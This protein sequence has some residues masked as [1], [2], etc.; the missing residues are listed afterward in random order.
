MATFGGGGTNCAIPLAEA[1][2]H[3]RGR[4]F[5]GCV[6]LSDSESWV[7]TGRCGATDVLTEWEKF[8]GHL[9]ALHAGR[10]DPKLVCIDLQ[11]YVTGQA[12]DR[13]DVLNVG[14]FSDAVFDVVAG[15]LRN[16]GHGFVAEV[17]AIFQADWDRTTPRLADPPLV[18]GAPERLA[19]D[20]PRPAPSSASASASTS[21]DS[22][23]GE[24]IGGMTPL[25]A[26]SQVQ[27][28]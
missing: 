24:I 13:E 19:H 21:P 11:P 10:L 6:L 26:S 23:N 16:D 4:P 17:E 22:V 5:A 25:S 3:L 9:L 18:V 14:G 27:F 7:G 15:F 1:N 2:A 12:P 28:E 8:R 20:A